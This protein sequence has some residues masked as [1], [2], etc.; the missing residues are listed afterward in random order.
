MKRIKAKPINELGRALDVPDGEVAIFSGLDCADL[1]ESAKRAC[2]F[3]R[4]RG[5]CLIEG[6]SKQRRG[7]VHDQEET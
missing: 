1:A 6:Q 7:H 4:H 5:N 2:G 3:A